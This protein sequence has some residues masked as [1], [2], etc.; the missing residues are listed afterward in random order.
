MVAVADVGVL[1][2]PRA[3]EGGGGMAMW[4]DVDPI[5]PPARCLGRRPRMPVLTGAL[6]GR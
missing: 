5:S 6:P 3:T 2:S 1:M 4:D